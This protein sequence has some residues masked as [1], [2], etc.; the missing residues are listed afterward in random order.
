MSLKHLISRI[1]QG[2]VHLGRV[3]AIGKIIEDVVIVF[4]LTVEVNTLHVGDLVL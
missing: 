1:G 2:G 3:T 4:L